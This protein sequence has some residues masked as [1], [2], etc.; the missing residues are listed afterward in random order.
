MYSYI[1]IQM[2]LVIIIGMHLAIVSFK[3]TH[4]AIVTSTLSQGVKAQKSSRMKSQ[5]PAV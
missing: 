4:L 5:T 3:D 1:F 2:H